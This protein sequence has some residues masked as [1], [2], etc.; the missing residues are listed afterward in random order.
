MRDHGSVNMKLVNVHT[1]ARFLGL[2]SATLYSARWRRQHRVP[3][4]RLGHALRFRLADL[5]SWVSQRR[6]PVGDAAQGK[7]R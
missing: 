4:L 7:P 5:E 3:A 2:S 1:A 6:E